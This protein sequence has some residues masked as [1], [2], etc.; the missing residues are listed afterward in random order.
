MGLLTGC[1]HDN[2]VADGSGAGARGGQLVASI[3]NEPKSYNRFVS[4][5]APEELL[6]LLTQA[7]LVRVNRATGVPEP[8]LARDWTVAPDGLTWTVRLRDDVTFS[9]GVPFT[10]GDVVFTFEALYDDRAATELAS[11]VMVGGKPLSVRAV[12]DHT[13]VFALPA[14][15]GPGVT[16]LDSVPILPRHKLEG[17]LAQGAFRDAWSMTTPPGEIVGLGPFVVESYAP[18]QNLVLARN[19]RFWGRDAQGTPLPYLDRIELRLVPDQNAEVLRVTAGELDLMNSEVR[20]EDL[21]ALKP[22]ADRHALA[23]AEAGVGVNSSALWLNLT[24]NAKVARGRPWLQK[25]ELRQAISYAIDRRAIVD[26]VYLGAGEP[27]WGPVTPGHGEWYVPELPKTEFDRA[28][29]RTILAGIGLIDRTG[30]GLVDDA[31]GRTARFSIL[32]QKGNTAR[33]KTC[34]IVLEQL[35]QVGLAVDV[36]AVDI[37]SILDHYRARDYDAIYFGA[38]TNAPDPARNLDFWLSSGSF[39]YW[40]A[41]QTTP[42]TAWEAKIDDLMRQQSTTIDQAARRRLFAE[43]QRVLA[44]ELP[45]LHFAVPKVTIAIASRVRGALPSVLQPPVLWNAETLSIVTPPGSVTRR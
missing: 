27:I 7:T 8:R 22:L 20:P 6:S 36:V 3:R 26:Q 15:Y 10:A 28:R 18:G 43:A 42:A 23:L 21:V 44:A 2:P 33:E 25:T 13:V 38:E 19:A 1:R 11:S 31:G 45:T 37:G 35:R 34:A 14:V 24:P 40:N 29:A 41:E 12:D 4:A 17:A 16:L 5:R 32:T 30:D 9:D 39:H